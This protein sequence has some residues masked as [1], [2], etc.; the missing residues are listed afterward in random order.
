M[1]KIFRSPAKINVL[2]YLLGKREDGFYNLFSLFQLIDLFDEITITQS[3]EDSLSVSHSTLKPNSSNLCHKARALFKESTSIKNCYSIHLEKN[4]PVGGGLGG[5]SSNAATVLYALN[6]L[7]NAPLSQFQLLTL[8]Q[9]LGS[10]VPLFLV[11]PTTIGINR[12]DVCFPIDKLAIDEC[13]IAIPPFS[14]ATS[15]VFSYIKINEIKQRSSLVLYSDIQLRRWGEND[16]EK[17]AYRLFP[18]LFKIKCELIKCG[19]SKVF[20][21]GSGSSFVCLGSPH[22]SIKSVLLKK[23]KGLQHQFV[24]S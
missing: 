8:A 6:L 2:L 15:K 18:Q 5:G 14:I 1:A 20:L 19:F 21:S 22:T 4:I 13:W 17:V 3:N 23:V 9:K 12:G 11:G 24:T 7:N 16:L 10:D